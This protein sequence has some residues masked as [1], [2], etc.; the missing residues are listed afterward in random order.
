[1]DAAGEE[2]NDGSDVPLSTILGDS[3]HFR[4]FA[5]MRNQSLTDYLR[6]R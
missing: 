4:R 5:M 1:M 2:E 3:D 6:G